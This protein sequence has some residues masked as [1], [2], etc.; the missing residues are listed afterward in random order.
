[1]MLQTKTSMR[2]FSFI[3]LFVAI[4]PWE[5]IDK[6]I[7]ATLLALF[8]RFVDQETRYSSILKKD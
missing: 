2:N 8:T 4:F 1:M 3:V 6:G 5:K 7:I